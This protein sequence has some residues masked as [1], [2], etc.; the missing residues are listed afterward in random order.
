MYKSSSLLTALD[1]MIV[2]HLPISG[3]NL[4]LSSSILLGYKARPRKCIIQS[5]YS[6]NSLPWDAL[7]NR[8]SVPR[9]GK[10]LQTHSQAAAGVEASRVGFQSAPCTCRVAP[11]IDT[12][13][14]PRSQEEAAL[15]GAHTR[16]PCAAGAAGARRCAAVRLCAPA[17]LLMA[18]QQLSKGSKLGW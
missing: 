2:R 6:G 14:V 17:L 7:L 12:L 1:K 18:F 5:P 11:L 15:I 8:G 3:R 10:K 9:S 4:A 16:P 13:P